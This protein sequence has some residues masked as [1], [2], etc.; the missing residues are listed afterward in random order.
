[1]RQP[2]QPARTWAEEPR[3]LGGDNY[4]FAD[5]SARWLRRKQ[6]PDGT[7]AK[8]PEADVIWEAVVEE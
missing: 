8:E 6:L 4:G 3:H 5:G 2:R 7:W 1:V